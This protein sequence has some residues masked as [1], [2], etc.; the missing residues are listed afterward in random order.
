[1]PQIGE[2][3]LT[4]TREITDLIVDVIKG[5]ISDEREYL[6]KEVSLL[7]FHS[8]VYIRQVFNLL[9]RTDRQRLSDLTLSLMET[10]LMKPAEAVIYVPK[11]SCMA[12]SQL[13]KCISDHPWA[14][15]QCPKRRQMIAERSE[16][17][18]RNM[19]FLKKLSPKCDHLLQ[20]LSYQFK[21][22]PFFVT[23]PVENRRLLGYLLKH[24]R[25]Q[26]WLDTATLVHITKQILQGLTFLADRNIVTRDV[27]AYNMIVDMVD[28]EEKDSSSGFLNSNCIIKLADLGLAHEFRKDTSSYHDTENR[29]VRD[30][31]PIPVRW[32]APEALFEG[33]HTDK[34][35]VYSVGCVMYELWTHGCQPFTSYDSSKTTEDLLIQ[36][37]RT[38]VKEVVTAKFTHEVLPIN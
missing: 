8:A 1:M 17:H 24:R 33:R 37:D 15:E 10:K 18:S 11:A 27:T 20:L 6:M 19:D 23:E 14:K 25:E 29:P 13:E 32:T 28:T 31:G 9:L 35:M 22:F 3:Q 16:R 30:Q 34:S 2:G 4:H 12:G 7:P 38:T 36:D 26:R 5:A 21:P